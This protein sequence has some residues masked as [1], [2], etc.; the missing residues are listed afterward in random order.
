M[1]T[2]A[3]PNT[4][5]E[6]GGLAYTTTGSECLNLFTQPVRD[7]HVETLEV[8]LD[9][10]WMEDPRLTVALIMHL[11]DCR[12]G[13]GEKHLGVHAM[14]WLRSKFP[15]TFVQNVSKV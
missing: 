12:G 13:K 11:R 1:C 4:K 15:R 5:G 10:A 9:K 14:L 2:N 7:T 3:L 6:N 8:M